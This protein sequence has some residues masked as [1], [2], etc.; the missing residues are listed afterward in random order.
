MMQGRPTLAWPSWQ[1][2]CTGSFGVDQLL[3]SAHLR[4]IQATSSVVK[5]ATNLTM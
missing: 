5:K 2:F 3:V 1:A 4:T